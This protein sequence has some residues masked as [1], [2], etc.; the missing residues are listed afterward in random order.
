MFP[1]TRD[2]HCLKDVSSSC[3]SWTLEVNITEAVYIWYRFSRVRALARCLI[4]PNSAH[5]GFHLL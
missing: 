1:Y 4:L 5:T 3:V 2:F